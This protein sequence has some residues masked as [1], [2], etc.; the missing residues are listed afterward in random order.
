MTRLGNEIREEGPIQIVGHIWQND[1]DWKRFLVRRHQGSG[2]SRV[3]GLVY[4]KGSGVFCLRCLSSKVETTTSLSSTGA[5]APA[6][7]C[8]TCGQSWTMIE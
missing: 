3:D 6:H 1:G 5:N 7:R 8:I 2:R 4:A